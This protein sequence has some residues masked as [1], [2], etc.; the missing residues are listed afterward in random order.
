MLKK[1]LYFIGFFYLFIYL[2]LKNAR[3]FDLLYYFKISFLLFPTDS[4]CHNPVISNCNS[5]LYPIMNYTLAAWFFHAPFKSCRPLYT[6]GGIHSCAKNMDLPM[7]KSEC[8]NLC[9]KYKYRVF[10]SEWKILILLLKYIWRIRKHIDN[11]RKHYRDTHHKQYR[12]RVKMFFVSGT[13]SV[14]GLVR[15]YIFTSIHFISI[16]R[17]NITGFISSIINLRGYIL[18]YIYL[19]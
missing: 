3:I 4:K 2:M 6:P 5:S 1:I 11:M 13:R 8:E 19:R 18:V 16:S 7:T 17:K 15:Q 10:H 14:S 9:S 12:R